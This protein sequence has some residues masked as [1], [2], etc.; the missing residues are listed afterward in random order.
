MKAILSTTMDDLYLFNLPF[1]VYSWHLVGAGSIIFRT[2]PRNSAEESKRQLVYRTISEFINGED[3]QP[4]YHYIET[5]KNREATY[6]QCARLFAAAIEVLQLDLDEILVTADADM[7]VFQPNYWPSAIA[8]DEMTVIGS[9]LV[10]GWQVPMCYIKGSVRSWHKLSYI[11]GKNVQQCLD[12]LL[13]H[14]DTDNMRGNYWCKDQETAARFLRRFHGSV[15]YI[16][17]TDG[18]SPFATRRADRDG[19]PNP[20][21]LDILDAHL[22]RPGYT[23]ENFNKIYNLFQTM[24][25]EMDHSWMLTYLDEYLKL[26]TWR[27]SL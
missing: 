13:G 1:A 10:D 6:M 11:Y 2:A 16:A 20:I 19:W 23:E 7:C 14:I 21:P 9:D 8:Q 3:H 17:R 26:I 12:E 22:P 15:Q 24:Y 25:P 18:K 27:A 5:D 4:I